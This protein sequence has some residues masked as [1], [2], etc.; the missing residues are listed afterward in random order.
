MSK[1]KLAKA[2]SE[3]K[4]GNFSKADIFFAEAEAHEEL[5]LQEFANVAFT[6][7]E[8]AAH[9]LRW[10]DA[11]EHYARA[12]RLDPCFNNLIMAQRLAIDIGDYDS[13]L[14]FGIEAQKTAI[15]EY[16]EDSEEHST[17]LNNIGQTYRARG[18]NN[19]AEPLHREALRIRKKILGEDNRL[20]ANSYSSLAG[21]YSSQGRYKE[22]EIFFKKAL[23]IDIKILEADDIEI[24]T[25]MNNLGTVYDYQEKY[26]DAEFYYQKALKI[27]K[28]SLTK[29]H[30]SIANSLN[31]L[32]VL[33][34]KTN[35]SK[36][37]ELLYQRAIKILEGNFGSEHPNT[38]LVQANYERF[39]NMPAQAANVAV[40]P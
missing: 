1:D 18:Q 24:A 9:E 19:K 2:K 11:A 28:K 29:N 27:R 34:E 6:R 5:T 31:N 22:A 15:S 3:I 14:F 39:I 4:A 33:Y 23:E 7:G 10:K 16:G 36:G 40:A 32:A 21:V 37:I 30:P 35:K 8:I 25:A 38:K 12:A 17:S 26:D 13:A 20:T